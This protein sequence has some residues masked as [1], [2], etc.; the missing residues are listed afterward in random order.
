MLPS[1][2]HGRSGT[3]QEC[4][5]QGLQPLDLGLEVADAAAVSDPSGVVLR[6]L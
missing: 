2:S 6:P 4:R 1:F 3:W 5:D